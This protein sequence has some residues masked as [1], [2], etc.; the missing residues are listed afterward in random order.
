LPNLSAG[1]PSNGIET[2]PYNRQLKK[3]PHEDV[4]PERSFRTR[5]FRVP[6]GGILIDMV[7]SHNTTLKHYVYGDDFFL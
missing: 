1:P 7:I 4:I 2:P 6:A 3:N 5:S